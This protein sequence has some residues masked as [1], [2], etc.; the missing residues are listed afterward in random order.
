M[1]PPSPYGT[2]Q[3]YLTQPQ[4]MPVQYATPQSTPQYHPAASYSSGRKKALFVGINYKGTQNALGGCINDANNLRRFLIQRYGYPADNTLVLTDDSPDY[5]RQPTYQNILNAI[6]WLMHDARPGDSLFFSYSGHGSQTADLD[7]SRAWGEKDDTICPVDFRTAGQITSTQL[8][9]ALVW[10][11]PPDARLT[12]FMDCCHSGTM[13]EL[14]FTY[15]PDA[16]GKMDA[17]ELVKRGMTLALEANNLINGRYGLNSMEAA[18][19][20]FSEAKTFVAQLS[21]KS[22]VGADGYKVENFNNPQ[23]GGPKHVYLISGCMD[24]QTSAD[25]AINGMASGALTYAVLHTLQEAPQISFEQ[26]LSSLRMWMRQGN[27]S[28]VPQLSCGVKVD[29]ASLFYL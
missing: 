19:G 26:L 7:G 11:L 9:H 1:P 15:R 20:L 28:Q 10:P 16:N 12:V 27:Y 24:E 2:Q 17:V 3:Q 18:K 8:H 21:G 29:P 13:L 14:P 4:Q 25:T 5:S 6:S 22:D 23:Y